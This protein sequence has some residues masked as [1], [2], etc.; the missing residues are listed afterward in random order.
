MMFVPKLFQKMN[1]DMRRFSK[2]VNVGVRFQ[3]N[4]TPTLTKTMTYKVI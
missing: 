3:E 4:F 1:S 2:N